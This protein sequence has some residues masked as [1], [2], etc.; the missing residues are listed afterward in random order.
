MHAT[1]SYKFN[2]LVSYGRQFQREITDEAIH[3]ANKLVDSFETV[4]DEHWYNIRQRISHELRTTQ[5]DYACTNRSIAAWLLWRFNAHA[6]RRMDDFARTDIWP[7]HMLTS[8]L[9]TTVVGAFPNQQQLPAHTA[10]REPVADHTQNIFISAMLREGVMYGEEEIQTTSHCMLAEMLAARN[11]EMRVLLPNSMMPM[12]IAERCGVA[13]HMLETI[14]RIRSMDS[15]GAVERTFRELGFLHVFIAIRFASYA[16][17]TGR[18][19]YI[20]PQ[21]ARH[22]LHNTGFNTVLVHVSETDLII[23]HMS[24]W[25][26]VVPDIRSEQSILNTFA[27]VYENYK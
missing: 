15:I 19:A 14:G 26:A 18:S 27:C 23:Q 25:I 6:E 22:T 5:Y 16:N 2:Q 8:P 1:A 12:T 10:V 21:C 9:D 3:N 4:Q 17:K 11:I 13:S 20:V 24:G 7:K